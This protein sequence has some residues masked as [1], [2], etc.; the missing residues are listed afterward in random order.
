MKDLLSTQKQSV[1]RT[2][3][4]EFYPATVHITR[5]Y[6]AFKEPWPPRLDERSGTARTH[7]RHELDVIALLI[8]FV[9]AAVFT[10]IIK[11]FARTFKLALVSRP[12][13]GLMPASTLLTR[14][15]V[16]SLLTTSNARLAGR[17]RTT[18]RRRHHYDLDGQP[19]H[20]DDEMMEILRRIPI[21]RL[22]T[23][24]TFVMVKQATQS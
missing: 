22:S 11:R 12:H 19:V 6:G 23:L 1:F 5:P 15:K 14:L 4:L 3:L 10:A 8:F 7:E 2:F 20:S 13:R 21:G 24:F 18:G 17:Q 9:S 16:V